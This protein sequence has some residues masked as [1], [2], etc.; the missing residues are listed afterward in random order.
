MINK[1]EN[2]KIALVGGGRFCEK[3]LKHLFSDHFNGRHPEV[4]GVADINT[5]AVGMVYARSMG[6]HT[7]SDFR[8]IC[9]LEGLDTII[10]VTWDL[11]LAQR[12][13][14]FKPAD[15]ELVDHQDSRFLWDLLQLETIRDSAL[16]ALSAG[17]LSVEEVKARVNQ[18]FRKTADIVM[19]RNRRFKQIERELYENEKSLSQII[20]GSTIPTFV[21]NRDHV[22]THWNRSLE[23]LTGY[24]AADLVGTR[25][26]WKPFRK[27]QRPIMADVILDQ[28]ETGEINHYY[29]LLQEP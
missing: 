2:S 9:Q 11:D 16:S 7:C 21:I 12:I 13:A 23:T 1:I 20:Q 4:L 19:H 29:G 3:L 26:H 6:I 17:S 18:C 8:E 5:D 24:R 15:V 25:D 28:L 22:V 27:Q 10:E 14:T